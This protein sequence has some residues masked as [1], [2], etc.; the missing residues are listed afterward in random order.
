MGTSTG[1]GAVCHPDRT[2]TP[3]DTYRCCQDRREALGRTGVRHGVDDERGNRASRARLGRVASPPVTA[4]DDTDYSHSAADYSVV[5]REDPVVRAQIEKA[6]GHFESAINVGAGSGS[7][8]PTGR[9]VV[10][11]EPS[12]DM[13]A[14]RPRHLPPAIN[15]VAGSLPFDDDVF[16]VALAVLTVHHWP[17]LEKGL[18]EMRRVTRGR[19]VIMT[20][21]PEALSSLWLASYSPAFHA[22]ERRRYPTIDRI[23]RALGGTVEALPLLIPAGCI[24]GFADAFFGRPE[25]MLDPAVRRS[26]SA[27]SFVSEREQQQFVRDLSEDLES[28]TWDDRFGYLRSQPEFH[29]SMRLVV[30][31]TG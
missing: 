21:D 24:D 14:Q 31:S 25:A 18:G 11:V 17:D 26:Q 30:A 4:W 2:R 27:W 23:A 16:D 5:R 9:H 3:A 7:Y 28:G 10:A 1:M 22:A 19:V 20:A 12:P 29:G 13:R 15:A 8:E 6:L